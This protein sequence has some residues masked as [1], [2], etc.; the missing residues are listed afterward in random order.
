MQQKSRWFM[1]LALFA[2]LFT[3]AACQITPDPNDGDNTDP[4]TT[5]TEPTDINALGNFAD[6][7]DAVYMLDINSTNALSLTFDKQ[8]FSFASVMKALDADFSDVNALNIT[9]QGSGT[10][11]LIKLETADGS[12]AREIQVNANTAQQSF[13]WDL[14][15]ETALLDGLGKILIFAAPG[16]E[17]EMGSVLISELVFT[18]AEATG[19]VVQSGFS[20]FVRPEPNVYTGQEGSFVLRNFYDGGDG[21]YTIDEIDGAFV[22]SYEKPTGA[23]DWAFFSADLQGEFSDFARLV[24]EFTSTV[25][26]DILFKIEGTAG[27]TETRVTGLGERQTFT[28]GLLA[29]LP[30]QLDNTNKLVIF[31]APGGPGSGDITLHSVR[32]ERAEVIINQ[33]WFGLDEGVYTTTENAD[34]SVDVAYD[35][36]DT[37]AWSVLKLDIPAAYQMLNVLTL[38]LSGTE[39]Q[40][41]IVKPNDDGS[42]EQNVTLDASGTI[43]LTFENTGGFENIIL[44]AMP[45]VG[46]EKGSF[47]IASAL[48]DYVA[49]DFDPTF[50][51]DFNNNWTEND[52]GTYTITT[53]EDGSVR[54]AY[55]I[56][57]FQ[58]VRR[59]FAVED[60]TGLNTMTV[61]IAGTPGRNVLLKPN[62]SGALERRVEFESSDPITVTFHADG[63]NSILMFA[64]GGATQAFGSFTILEATLSYTYESEIVGNDNYVVTET[65]EGIFEV[66]YTK[67]GNPWEFLNVAFDPAQTQGLNTLTVV[68]SGT[69][70]ESVLLK[71]NDLGSLEKAVTFTDANPVTEVFTFDSFSRLILFAQPGNGDAAGTFFIHSVTLTYVAPPAAS[72]DATEV[73]DLN[74]NHISADE[75]VYTFTTVATGV[76]VNYAKGMGQEWSFMRMNLAE[77]EG[78]DLN[79]LVVHLT[80][81]TEGKQVLLKPN[82]AGPLERWLTFD[83]QGEAQATIM[84]NGFTTLLIFAEGGT[85]SVSGSFII[86]VAEVRYTVDLLDETWVSLVPNAYMPSVTTAGIALSYAKNAGDDWAAVKIDLENTQG[87]NTLHVRI[88]GGVEGLK[89]LLKPNDLGPLEQMLTFNAQGIIDETLTF[90]TDITSMIFFVDPGVAPASG[91]VT[92][93]T[94]RLSYNE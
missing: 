34:G 78:S 51:Y 75:G 72:F 36:D 84:N 77:G 10:A 56:A 8:M 92:F 81:G 47:T 41:F 24:I 35:K 60:V 26:I 85:H 53:N 11:V 61:V 43:T 40:N 28:F 4:G 57:G 50:T 66:D 15:D 48:L 6:G 3:L 20:D 80:G 67:G 45:N 13:S 14:K 7:G 49:A 17:N 82:D 76:Q 70:G 68:L 23:N 1:F 42:I 54:F 69:V 55:A 39:G 37:Q 22:V 52:S 79:T 21:F 19:R 31:G 65:A 87:L 94:F 5:P 71:P 12:V 2:L 46:N 86:S 16:R 93:T 90:T 88:E 33:D 89:V 25:D 64:E 32:F 62:D 91:S 59:N 9:L 74:V 58:F 44:F 18:V 38:T 73:I 27:S 83:A 29:L 30:A 63:F